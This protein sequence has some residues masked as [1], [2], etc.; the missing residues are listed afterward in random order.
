MN[1]LIYKNE[2]PLFVIACVLAGLFWLALVIG[3]VGLALIG[4]A[5][6]WLIYLFAQSGFIAWIKGNGVEVTAD[7]F[8][9]LYN[10]FQSCCQKL[11][12]EQPPRLY[13]MNGEGM[14]NALATKFLNTQYVVLFS[15]TVDALERKPSLVKFYIGHELG[16][17]KRRHLTWQPLLLPV[18]WLPLFGAA[19]ARAREYTCD[20]HGL[21][22]ADSTADACFA[23]AVLA[24]GERKW[25][26][27]KF[28]AYN[29]QVEET[30]GF[31]M[32]FHEL[33]GD[34]PWLSKRVAALMNTGN[35]NGQ[36]PT[37]NPLA[38]LFAL[39]V[40][41]TGAGGGAP[42]IIIA[43]IGVLAAVALPAYK[44]YQQRAAMAQ[45]QAEM[46]AMTAT[47]APTAEPSEFDDS[48]TDAS[49]DDEEYGEEFSASET[50]TV[51]NSANAAELQR[52]L[53]GMQIVASAYIDAYQANRGKS[54]PLTLAKMDLKQTD[55]AEL[56]IL[57]IEFTDYA[58]TATL[59]VIGPDGDA[60]YL[61]LAAGHE[62]EGNGMYAQCSDTSLSAE[63]LIGICR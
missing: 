1:E 25:A 6:F 27:V 4:V 47:E 57:I 48:T 60:H 49:E 33:C 46:E 20:R 56:G 63:H 34:Y 42:I 59:D 3:T 51:D 53:T 38:Y 41:R 29:R 35:G 43:I 22:C 12:I 39:F 28:T 15:N 10:H 9:D 19:Y 11:E 58:M 13:L 23:M 31:W 30:S 55:L 61:R 54:A 2:K 52:A 24:A 62:E 7:Q 37:R 18:L 16:H 40:P 26:E 32:S 14:L 50:P 17:L 36:V 21:A 5:V 44:D 45:M 8:P